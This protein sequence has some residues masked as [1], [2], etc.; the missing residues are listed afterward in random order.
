MLKCIVNVAGT[1]M[2]ESKLQSKILKWLKDRGFWVIKTIVTNRNGVP[3]IIACAPDGKFVAIEV[4]FGKNTASKLQ[5]WNI[6]ELT[7]NN[8]IAFIAYDLETV[9]EHLYEYRSNSK[10]S[11]RS[12]SGLL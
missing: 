2:S 3:D 7:K 4:K 10:S 5:H 12:E 6:G 1:S 11:T 8:A 9:E